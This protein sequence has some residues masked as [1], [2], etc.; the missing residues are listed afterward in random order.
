MRNRDLLGGYQP[1]VVLVPASASGTGAGDL[2]RCRQPRAWRV[3]AA[4]AVRAADVRTR[5]IVPGVAGI[6]HP[7][8]ARLLDV[9]TQRLV[10]SA[11]RTGTERGGRE[12]SG[13]RGRTGAVPGRDDDRNTADLRR[14]LAD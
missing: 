3:L 1:G 13:A 9:R 8:H 11:A 14:R 7:G 12:A 10:L 2:R 6:S 5:R 4:A